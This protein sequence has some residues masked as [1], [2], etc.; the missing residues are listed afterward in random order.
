MGCLATVLIL[1]LITVSCFGFRF[2]NVRSET[3]LTHR[4]ENFH[5]RGGRLNGL[6]A[7]SAADVE[8][9]LPPEVDVTIETARLFNRISDKYMLLDV[10]GA[11][12]PGMINCC[13]SGCDNCEFRFR[14]DQ[15]SSGRA[16]WVPLYADRKHIDG[17]SHMAPWS[18]IFFDSVEDFEKAKQEVADEAPFLLT[19]RGD[20]MTISM[21]VFIDKIKEMPPVMSIGPP[22]GIGEDPPS[23]EFLTL[24]W[25]KLASVA[26]GATDSDSLTPSQLS[27]ALETL[28][29]AEHGATWKQFSAVFA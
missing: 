3:P 14:F 13:H 18:G 19:G 25:S 24:F 29:K 22:S 8:I 23:T 4:C 7:S 15:M 1:V 17:R 10:E 6:R 11:G 12:S 20:T 16:K 27:Q 21:D 26:G 2:A 5:K 9:D 28:T